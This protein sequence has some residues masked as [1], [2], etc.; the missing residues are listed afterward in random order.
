MAP[1][2]STIPQHLLDHLRSPQTSFDSAVDALEEWI[3]HR[4]SK[5]DTLF[6]VSVG[7]A[8][9]ED[10]TPPSACRAFDRARYVTNTPQPSDLTPPVGPFPLAR[11]ASPATILHHLL[12]SPTPTIQHSREIILEYVLAKEGKFREKKPG[13]GGKGTLGRDG[14]E[15]ISKRL[16][17]VEDGLRGAAV[18][19]PLKS[20]FRGDGD[21][22][23]GVSDQELDEPRKIG[24]ALILS[25]RMSLSYFTLQQLAD[26]LLLLALPD[27]ERTLVQHIRRRVQGEG[28]YGVGKELEYVEQITSPRRPA[29]RPVFRSAKTRTCIPQFPRYPIN[30]PAPSK[31]SCIKLLLAFAKDVD[32]GTS[33]TSYTTSLLPSPFSS[34]S[35]AEKGFL[36]R[37]PSA[38]PH[39]PS[40]FSPMSLS[41]SPKT[42]L[43]ALPQSPPRWPPPPLPPQL[44]PT[45]SALPPDPDPLASF[46]TEL[47]S[48]FITREKRESLLK[49]RWAKT[50]RDQL[51][52]D[53]A[54]IESSLCISS[55]QPS[56]RAPTLLPVFLLLRRTFALPPCPLNASIIEP[57]IDNLPA[58]PDSD[59]EPFREPT[60]QTTTV[61]LY[62]NPRLSE[63]EAFRV[64]EELVESE[65]ENAIQEGLEE[66]EISQWITL[67]IKSVQKRVRTRPFIPDSNV[68]LPHSF[69]TVH[70]T[71]FSRT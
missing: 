58:P 38:S 16:S 44:S 20:T 23:P 39:T 68:D 40:T 48:E 63:D 55:R 17:E 24:L 62:V 64:L 1:G 37:G 51:S 26:Q 29:L 6:E 22:P 32:T 31:S 60:V 52:K 54:D 61:Q 57:Y 56:A 36:R 34:P 27:A 33:L 30:L 45:A 49:L 14:F 4:R 18:T 10:R 66:D 50:G 67:Q 71:R 25:L 42:S 3:L 12:S 15:E 43:S 46:A 69:P 47:I 21:S 65:R 59:E 11:S 28:R 5:G 9:L 8:E 13:R 70:T 53:L 19:T 2:N 35:A 41:Q 7:L